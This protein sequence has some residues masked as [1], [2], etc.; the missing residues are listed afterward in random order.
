MLPARGQQL[1]RLGD[2]LL[3]LERHVP[4]TRVPRRQMLP[5]DHK[6][7]VVHRGHREAGITA[8]EHG[9]ALDRVFL[10]VLV[11]KRSG[12]LSLLRRNEIVQRLRG[13]PR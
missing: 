12:V 9:D 13:I 6:D 4:L 1:L 10:R 3:P 8:M 11:R 5:R 2:L 7:A